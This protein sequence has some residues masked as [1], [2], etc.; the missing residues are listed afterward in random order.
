LRRNIRLKVEREQ[1]ALAKSGFEPTHMP[2]GLS[3][4]ILRPPQIT[5]PDD[6]EHENPRGE[7]EQ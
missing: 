3:H 6:E 5:K 1:L 7:N 2:P 4:G